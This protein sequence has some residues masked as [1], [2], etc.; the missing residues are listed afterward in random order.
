VPSETPFPHSSIPLPE[1]EPTPSI[2][3]AR[4]VPLSFR[5]NSAAVTDANVIQIDCD[6]E[7]APPV[8]L[9]T[10]PSIATMELPPAHLEWSSAEPAPLR[11]ALK[12]MRQQIS[13]FRS[14]RFDVAEMAAYSALAASPHADVLLPEALPATTDLVLDTQERVA[15]FVKSLQPRK[16]L[17]ELV[18][19]LREHV[20]SVEIRSVMDRLRSVALKCASN[21]AWTQT[22][23]ELLVE[24]Q[25]IYWHA[26][27]RMLSVRIH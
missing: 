18:A 2:D 20:K 1:I 11:E 6:Y 13:H 5:N 9:A 12:Q 26:L 7:S 14:L 19:A 8:A 25:T 4:R 16:Q 27:L 10:S 15:D 17:A 21:Q 23:A 22:K 24:S 3:I